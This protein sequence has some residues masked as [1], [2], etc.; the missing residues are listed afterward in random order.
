VTDIILDT[1]AFKIFTDKDV[2][3]FIDKVIK[4]CDHIYVP[5][6]IYKQLRGRFSGTINLIYGYL[7]KLDKKFHEKSS[8]E[9]VELPDRIEDEL[10]NNSAD[11]FDKKVA[12]LAFKRSKEGSEV[13]L[14]SNDRCFI[15]TSVL[16]EKFKIY[17]K[18]YEG[19]KEEYL[20][21][22]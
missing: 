22:Q 6:N 10:E 15:N 4:K 2:H 21:N 9:D 3:K 19:F 14:I 1:I 13:Y 7:R 12:K 17:V 8:F 11:E 16:F 5:N 18:S 20:F